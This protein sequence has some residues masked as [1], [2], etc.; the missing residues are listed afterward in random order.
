MRITKRQLQTIIREELT[1]TM[2]HSHVQ[3]RRPQLHESIKA[4]TISIASGIRASAIDRF[5]PVF[6]GKA[7]TSEEAIAIANDVIKIDY[8][9]DVSRLISDFRRAIRRGDNIAPVLAPLIPKDRSLALKP[10]S[11]VIS[12]VETVS[13]ENLND[14]FIAV[15]AMAKRLTGSEGN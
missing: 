5:M 8:D 10:V 12:A 6:S 7:V 2:T 13:G 3:K 15:K 14:I 9:G 1:R 4:K 11:A